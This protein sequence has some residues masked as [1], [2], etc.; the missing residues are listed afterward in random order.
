MKQDIQHYCEEV[1]SLGYIPQNPNNCC[2]RMCHS[3]F[4]IDRGFHLVII[5]S[6]IVPVCCSVKKG[7]ERKAKE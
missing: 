3:S 2:C 7:V 1:K 5:G 4:R 6:L